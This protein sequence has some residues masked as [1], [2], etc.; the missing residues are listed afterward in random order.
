MNREIELKNQF[1]GNAEFIAAIPCNI[2][3]WV[4]ALNTARERH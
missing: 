3:A 1:A 2:V 4:A